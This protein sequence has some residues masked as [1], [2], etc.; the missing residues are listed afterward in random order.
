MNNSPCNTITKKDL[1]A[2]QHKMANDLIEELVNTDPDLEGMLDADTILD[3]LGI[4]GFSLHIGDESSAAFL[5]G[6]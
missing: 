5:Q 6:V 2:M 3:C 4:C 1:I